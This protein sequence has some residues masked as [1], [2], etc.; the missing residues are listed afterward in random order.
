MIPFDGE[1][2]ALGTPTFEVEQGKNFGEFS[3]PPKPVLI[4]SRSLEPVRNS[5]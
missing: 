3:N 4:G 2:A 1:P 5:R